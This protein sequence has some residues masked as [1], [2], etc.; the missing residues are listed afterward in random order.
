[1]HTSR[2]VLALHNHQPIGNFGSVFESAFRDSYEPFLEL[3]GGYPGIRI[4]LHISGCLLEWLV[5]HHPE[6][7]DRLRELVAQG[8]VEILGGGF[9][10]PILAMIP[11]H[12][13]RGQIAA[14]SRYLDDLF[15]CR[16]RGMW[17]P[18][19]VWEQEL[20]RDIAAVGIEFSV[21]DDFHFKAAGLNDDELLGY[22]LTEDCGKLLKIFPGSERLRYCIPFRDPGDTMAYAREIAARHPGAVLVFADD[23]EKFGTWPETKKHV[24]QDGWLRRFFDALTANSD[25][26][27][28]V[29][30]GEVV[31]STLPV[32]KVYL[33]DCS[34]REMTEW[35]LRA[36]QLVDH[37]QIA[38]EMEHDSR[39]QRIRPYIR[40]GFWRNFKVKYPETDTMY[41][42]MVEVS[43]RLEQL[44]PIDRRLAPRSGQ[45]NGEA[46]DDAAPAS[47]T[48]ARQELY[49]AQCNC[50]WWHGSFG[51]LYLPHLRNA[52]FTHLIQAENAIDQVA[53]RP[54]PWIEARSADFNLDSRPEVRLANEKLIAYVAPSCGGQLYELDVRSAPINLLATLTRRPEAYHA[55]VLAHAGEPGNGTARPAGVIF[56]QDGLDRKVTYDPYRRQALIDRFLAHDVQ[57]QDLVAGRAIEHGDFI[58]GVYHARIRRSSE[59]VQLLLT[60]TGRVAE[61]EIHATK[62]ISLWNEGATLEVRYVL[63][64]VP[65]HFPFLFAVEF[66][67]AG[68]AGNAPDRYFYTPADRNLGPLDSELELGDTECVGMVDEWLGIDLALGFSMPADF[69]TYPVQ[70]VSQSESG[71]ELVYQSSVLLPRWRVEPDARGRWSVDITLA[72]D[73]SRAELRQRATVFV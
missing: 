65:R 10:E 64:N 53:G 38:H 44:D 62:A 23:G 2:L 52:V 13:R 41:C 4:S 39:W 16:V 5:Q 50:P 28:T 37:Q 34:Y 31:D 14:Y 63:E 19:R 17:M 49:R 69:V 54:G 55:R 36:P 35:A 67:F 7:V 9:Y 70:T 57:R 56:K 71:F 42:R 15:E 68:M 21:L 25:W 72:L 59:R 51:G 73:T 24:Y 40:G 66:G 58:D 30:F 1:M 18:E 33:P 8:R 6:Y 60:R 47:L 46:I 32:G 22:Y 3:L 29:P 12:D 61:Y 11:P 26:L 27:Q 43:Q 48:T 45:S 20:V